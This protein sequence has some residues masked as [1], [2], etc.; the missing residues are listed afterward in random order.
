MMGTHAQNAISATHACTK[1]SITSKK[2]R[3]IQKRL[4]KISN[5]LD[6]LMC[7]ICLMADPNEFIENLE[8]PC[9]ILKKYEKGL[10]M[11]NDT[12]L[13]TTSKAI[14]RARDDILKDPIS[15]VPNPK[16]PLKPTTHWLC[17]TLKNLP[18][19]AHES[20]LENTFCP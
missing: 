14:K 8:V 11:L 19:Y 2:V 5:V 16:S 9:D 20:N 17:L 18:D 12:I 7:K 10:S 15:S 13:N 6:G 1:L 3:E 4:S